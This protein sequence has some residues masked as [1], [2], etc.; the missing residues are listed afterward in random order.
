MYFQYT[1]IR[2]KFFHVHF[3]GRGRENISLCVSLLAEGK[4]PYIA[5]IWESE[6]LFQAFGGFDF[7]GEKLSVT[8]DEDLAGG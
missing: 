6:K 3:R 2:G 1:S 8:G 5:G 4:L 7:L